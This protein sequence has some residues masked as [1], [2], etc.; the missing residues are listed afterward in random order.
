MKLLR[1]KTKGCALRRLER[2]EVDAIDEP[3]KKLAAEWVGN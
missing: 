3:V 1:M 2:T